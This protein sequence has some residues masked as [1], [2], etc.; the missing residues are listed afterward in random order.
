M[1]P[2]SDPGRIGG[3]MSRDA[4][5]RHQFRT[6]FQSSL[7][8]NVRIEDFSQRFDQYANIFIN[9][10]SSLSKFCRKIHESV[11]SRYMEYDLAQAIKAVAAG[12]SIRKASLEWGIPRATL[13]NRLSGRESH[14]VTAEDQQSLSPV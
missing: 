3:V 12:Q 13:Y 7:R 2:E 4:T 11:V 10:A 14:R 6:S 9:F 8:I 5:F 1:L